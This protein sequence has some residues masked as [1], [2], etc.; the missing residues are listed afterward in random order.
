M[1]TPPAPSSLIIATALLVGGIAALGCPTG[2]PDPGG[3]ASTGDPT[4]GPDLP[5]V[6]INCCYELA[7][8]TPGIPP[9]I[10]IGCVDDNASPCIDPSDP[11][12]D[13]DFSGDLDASELQDI[14]AM[15]C[16]KPM[17]FPFSG[18]PFH[19]PGDPDTPIDLQGPYDGCIAVGGQV[20]TTAISCDPSSPGHLAPWADGGTPTHQGSLS[21][22]TPGNQ[23]EVT[24]NGV[25]IP[26]AFDGAF[27]L[28]IRDC[29]QEANKQ[30]CTLELQR[31]DL[32]LLGNPIFGGYEVTGGAA[33]L[34]I[35]QT[36]SVKFTCGKSSCEGLF[37][38]SA[39]AGTPLSLNMTW[40]Q[41]TTATGSVGG[42][43]L[44][45][46]NGPGSLGGMKKLLGTL[47][48]DTTLGAGTLELQGNGS[49]AL[50]GDFA[51]ATFDIAGPVE[52]RR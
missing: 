2:D 19:V 51:S 44:A 39:N 25:S 43:T 13:V 3:G 14:C 10:A 4:G 47:V 29:S 45:L 23:A 7:N 12:L 28:A 32:A 41:L 22:A 6:R 18:G 36:T 50:G 31:L 20:S 49:D 38:F 48:L 40:D 24:I 21:S 33:E 17:D 42:G 9:K 35:S 26:V 5:G 46:S 34:A 52:V 1:S 37:S 30:L 16:P 11:L 15:K 8:I 27:E